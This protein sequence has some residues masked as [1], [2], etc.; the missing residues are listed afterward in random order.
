[1]IDSS[2]TPSE[3]L[4]QLIRTRRSVR[5]FLPK[6]IPEELLNQV[7]ADANWSPSWSNTQLLRLPLRREIHAPEF[8]MSFATFLT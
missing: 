2:L 1:M 7:L 6:A 5:D 8:P 3:T 4:S